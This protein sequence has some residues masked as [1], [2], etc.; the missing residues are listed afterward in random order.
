MPWTI[1]DVDRHKAGLTMRQKRTWVRVANSALRVCLARN[2]TQSECEAAAIRQAN[3]MAGR[4]SPET[5]SAASPSTLQTIVTHVGFAV[6]YETLDDTVYLVAPAVPIIEGVLNDYYVPREE[7]AAFVDAWNGIP[8]PVGHPQ[9]DYGEHVSANTPARLEHAVGRFFNAHMDGARLLGEIWLN[10][11]KCD[12]LGGDAAECLRRFE[13]GEALEISTAF[14]SESTEVSGTFHDVAY[15][16]MHSH[17][18]P[19]HIALLPT[20]TGAC[21]CAMGCGV[22]TH[23]AS[24]CPAAM[25]EKPAAHANAELEVNVQDKQGRFKTAIQT[26]LSFASGGGE[27]GQAP[28]PALET[29]L[30][31][32]DL[33]MTLYGEL[34]RRRGMMYGPDFI[35]DIEDGYVIYKDGERCFRQA[36][37][38]GE[39]GAVTLTEEREEVQRNTRYVPVAAMVET[40]PGE[41]A[42]QQ[43]GA[44]MRTKAELVQALIAHQQTTW[45]ETDTAM[46]QT[47]SAEQLAR[48]VTEAEGRSSHEAI[49]TNSGVTVTN[50]GT[51][52]T[53]VIAEGLLMVSPSPVTLD[54][55]Q[56]LLKSE[57]DVRDQALEG[58]LAVYSQ[59]ANE[60]SERAQLVAHLAAPGFTEQ[61]C[62]GM[63]LDALRKVAQT[64][65]P[66]TFAGMG[67]PRFPSQGQEEG[68]W[69]SDAPDWSK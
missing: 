24:G 1:D 4:V 28:G 6:R 19:D 48:L 22:R 29:N 67:F 44:S 8:I 40:P 32:D 38:V 15:V 37:T 17:L 60:Q 57:L 16:G 56:A 33:R 39:D 63:T 45:G 26:I 69:P 41:Q 53:G 25:Q 35:M 30:T 66:A 58:K 14:W 50:D 64:V 52:A 61:D 36:Y 3:A 11:A 59:R 10:M 7:I 68:D 54:A 62:A 47:F 34:A 13:A 23:N 49:V 27:E 43:Q 42:S 12:R 21:S 18:R 31:H 51:T 65:A 2:G 46:L 5:N 55:I 20:S 9:N